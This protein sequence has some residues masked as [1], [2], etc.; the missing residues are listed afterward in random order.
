MKNITRL[1]VIKALW[2]GSV[3]AQPVSST[4]NNLKNGLNICIGG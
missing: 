2:V 1:E 4:T 3:L